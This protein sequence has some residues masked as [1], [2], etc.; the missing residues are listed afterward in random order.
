M[1]FS[2]DWIL[3]DFTKFDPTLLLMGA[4]LVVLIIFMVR[5]SR[6]RRRDAAEMQD[7]V[8]VGA[9]VMTNFGVYAHI[10]KIDD[11]DNKVVLE[12]S[13]GNTLTVHRQ[14][15][16]RVVEAPSATAKSASA[17]QAASQG[18]AKPAKDSAKSAGDPQFGERVQKPATKPAR[19][20]AAGSSK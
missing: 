8:K 1:G 7:K 3:V 10:K 15:I 12:T 17:P 19:K 16:S 4:V 20:P 5:N 18:A 11:V 9:E 14:V 6:K 13:P 2:F